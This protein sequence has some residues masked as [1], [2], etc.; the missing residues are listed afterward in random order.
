M[1]R[2]CERN[3]GKLLFPHAQPW[4]RHQ[5]IRLVFLVL[6]IEIAIAGLIVG[7]ALM[8]DAKWK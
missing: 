8:N 4:K 7:I 2:F 5:K 6:L 3:M 1:I